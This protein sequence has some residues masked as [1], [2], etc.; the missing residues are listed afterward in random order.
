MFQ[1]VQQDRVSQGIVHQIEQLVLEGALRPGDALP[2]ERD[3]AVQFNVSR[4]T[5]REALAQLEA[6]GLLIA[7]QGGG[8][9]IANVMRSIFAEP[10]IGLFSRHEKATADYLEFRQEMETQAAR[11]A[12][13]R[14]TDADREI[15]TSIMEQMHAAHQDEDPA[16]EARLDVELHIAV[17]D[18]S[19]NIV[20][21]QT[22][23]SIYN[24]L[25]H[26][27]FHNRHLLYGH[28]GGREALLLQH[29][30]IYDAVM[31]RDPESAAQAVKAHM[32]AVAE[33]WRESD[34]VSRRSQIADRRL[35]QH[36]ARK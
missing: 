18:A 26:G 24:L 27:V 21:T 28:K 3:L 20:M 11:W 6:S 35:Q 1:P 34:A 4:P 32:S 30:A 2:A 33:A 5:L 23:R 22:L 14:A 7:R 36:K 29:K 9:F 17:S 25:Q 19:H 10:I 15:L 13:V 8:T 31:A 12:A 16:E